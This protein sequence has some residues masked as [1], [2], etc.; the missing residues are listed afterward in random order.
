[1]EFSL[2]LGGDSSKEALFDSNRSQPS[3]S[4]FL[5]Y[6]RQK[7]LFKLCFSANSS[8]IPCDLLHFRINMVQYIHNSEEKFVKNMDSESFFL[9]NFAA[10]TEIFIENFVE[11]AFIKY[12]LF[13]QL[14]DLKCELLKTPSLKAVAHE[15]TRALSLKNPNFSNNH[16]TFLLVGKKGSGKKDILSKLCRKFGLNYYEK[17]AKKISSIKALEKSLRKAFN[18]RPVL[19]NIR[20]FK[21]LLHVVSNKVYQDPQKAFVLF[22]KDF[23]EEYREIGK[24]SVDQMP[25]HL[26]F[27]CD[28]FEDLDPF[29]NEIKNFFDFIAKIKEFEK[30]ELEN[31]WD[32]AIGSCVIH[33]NS[34]KIV[35]FEKIA[36][37]DK[38]AII[39]ELSLISK[40]IPWKNL[41]KLVEK[42]KIE[43]FSIENLKKTLENYKKNKEFDNPSIPNVK[44][45]DVGG[46]LEAKKD[47]IDTIMLPQQYPQIF[48]EFMRPRTGLLFYG[49]PGTFIYMYIFTIFLHVFMYIYL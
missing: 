43:G 28:K 46:L 17:D 5:D 20:N 22:I 45:E 36:N 49:P 19:V 39:E 40:G 30:K 34:E 3:P 26:F 25:C 42:Q 4:P 24:T 8:L 18:L 9:M 35:I 48:N 6:K 38:N 23:I 11:A 41:I 12:P 16:R 37:S 44:W 47:I 7:K 32:L 33:E 27:T 31:F 13:S 2:F 14:P 10:E 21:A 29:D 15:I 1:M